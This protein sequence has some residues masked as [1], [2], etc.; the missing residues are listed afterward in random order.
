MDRPHI[1]IY[2][3]M[4]SV[5]VNGPF[6]ENALKYRYGFMLQYNSFS[7]HLKASVS[8]KLHA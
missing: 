5:V 6:L 3:Y 2:I 8:K 7:N 4:Y 1:H